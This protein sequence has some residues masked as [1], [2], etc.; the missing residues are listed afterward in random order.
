MKRKPAAFLCILLSVLLCGCNKGTDTASSED[1]SLAYTRAESSEYVNSAES[2]AASSSET[3]EASGGGMNSTKPRTSDSKPTSACSHSY[4]KFVYP[5]SCR[6]GHTDYECE[7]C[8]YKYTDNIV[9]ANG[10]H[11]FGKYLCDNCGVA[12]P[13]KP[14]QSLTVWVGKHG[15]LSGNGNFYEIQK[16]YGAKKYVI[17]VQTDLREINSVWFDCCDPSTGNTYSLGLSDTAESNYRY[18]VYDEKGVLAA[19]VLFEDLKNSAVRSK[20]LDIS[21]AQSWSAEGYTI[22][23]DALCTQTADFFDEFMYGINSV[24]GSIKCGLTVNDFGFKTF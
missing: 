22:D 6:N 12:D 2:R 13:S 5:P 23:K 14:I 16:T 20:N 7:K 4:R 15:G 10:R 21:A 8:G 9:S 11:L 19:Y 24:L 1:S 3:S 17:T 18:S